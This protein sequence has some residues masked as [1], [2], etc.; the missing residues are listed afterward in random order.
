[1]TGLK[2][3]RRTTEKIA[4]Q[5]RALGIAVGSNTVGRLLKDMDFLLRVNH[6]KLTNRVAPD[7]DEQ[8]THIKRMRT[9]FARR[10]WPIVSVDSKKREQVGNF[11]NNGAAWCREA[12]PV[13]DHDFRSY[14]SGIAIPNGVYDTQANKASIFVGTSYDTSLFAVDSLVK[15]WVY[16]GRRRYPNT[17]RLLVLADGGGSNGAT[18]HAW[19]WGLQQLSRSRITLK[20][21]CSCS[22]SSPISNSTSRPMV[23]PFR[24]KR[25]SSG[26]RQTSLRPTHPSVS[27]RL[28]RIVRTCTPPKVLI[29]RSLH[30]VT[31]SS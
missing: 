22:R 21:K 14:A 24:A 23:S 5:L 30:C 16:D 12:T 15:W 4:R 2:W 31:E 26:G 28:S 11:K 3:T 7:R 19:K 18:R 20:V 10:G 27:Q 6:K 8:F 9:L 29:V 13:N 17:K 1:M 25:N